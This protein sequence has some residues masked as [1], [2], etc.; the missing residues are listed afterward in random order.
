MSDYPFFKEVATVSDEEALFPKE[1]A[2]PSRF[3]LQLSC[4]FR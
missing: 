1:E 3:L 4:K 2:L